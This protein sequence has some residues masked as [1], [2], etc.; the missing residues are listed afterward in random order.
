MVVSKTFGKI[1]KYSILGD[2]VE[3]MHFTIGQSF[4]REEAC[5]A[6]PD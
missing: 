2:V 3:N 4:D 1:L 6:K 5:L